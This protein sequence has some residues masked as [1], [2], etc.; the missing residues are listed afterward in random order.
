MFP[1]N[2]PEKEIYDNFRS[3]FDSEDLSVLMI[4]VP[5]DHPLDV[6]SLDI[7]DDVV[8]EIKNI[9]NLSNCINLDILPC[10][11]IDEIDNET[12]YLNGYTKYQYAK[13]AH[14]YNYDKDLNRVYLREFHL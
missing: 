11:E 8:S 1:E 7:V 10:N 5:V 3:K 14:F 12:L 13:I 4:Y 6:S 2:D 9:K